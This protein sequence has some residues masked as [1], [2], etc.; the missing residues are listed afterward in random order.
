MR[1]VIGPAAAIYHL[2]IAAVSGHLV[3]FVAFLGGALISE[4]LMMS[5]LAPSTRFVVG[6]GVGVAALWIGYLVVVGLERERDVDGRIGPSSR[7]RS[8]GQAPGLG[9]E[10]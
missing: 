5:V 2:I 6:V 9:P 10:S 1:V 8:V 7:R 4:A 3:W